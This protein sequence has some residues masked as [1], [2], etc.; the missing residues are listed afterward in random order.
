[1]YNWWLI[2]TTCYLPE[3]VTKMNKASSSSGGGGRSWP[4]TTSVSTS[5]K[6]IQTEMGEL[7]LFPPADCSA[8]PIGDNLY[9]W[10]ATIIGPTGLTILP[11]SLISALAYFFS[12]PI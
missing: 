2:L 1:M 7:H 4:S 6:R 8:G 9:N 5:A 3:K 10:I 11:L 12:S